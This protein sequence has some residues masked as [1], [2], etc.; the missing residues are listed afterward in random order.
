MEMIIL[1]HVTE[2]VQGRF[3]LFKQLLGMPYSKRIETN[4]A[5]HGLDPLIRCSS[6]VYFPSPSQRSMSRYS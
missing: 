3:H 6:P 2:A 1:N 5:K 4:K